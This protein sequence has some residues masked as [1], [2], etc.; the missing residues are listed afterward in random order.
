M[1]PSVLLP[2]SELMVDAI[3]SFP[4]T[5]TVVLDPETNHIE[6]FILAAGTCLRS[7]EE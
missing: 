4:P 7:N 2:N 1:F 5:L 6:N 3:S